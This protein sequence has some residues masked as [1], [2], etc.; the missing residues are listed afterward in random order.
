MRNTRDSF[1]ISPRQQQTRAE[2]CM[3]WTVGVW[4]IFVD[5]QVMLSVLARIN[6]AGVFRH[7]LA[8]AT[9]AL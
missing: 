8:D 3:Q 4:R 5:S 7:D 6:R 2:A 9:F 1:G